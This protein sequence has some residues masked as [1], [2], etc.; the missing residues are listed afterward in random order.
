MRARLARHA[1]RGRVFDLKLDWKGAPEGG[2]AGE[3]VSIN[4]FSGVGSQCPIW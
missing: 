4:I 3:V 1:P 2:G